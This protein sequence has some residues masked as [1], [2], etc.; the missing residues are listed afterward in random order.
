MSSL[1]DVGS[2]LIELSAVK[3]VL[4]EEKKKLVGY[5]VD[6]WHVWSAS[7]HH[8]IHGVYLDNRSRW[9]IENR[10]VATQGFQIP[11]S[12][13]TSW[14]PNSGYS[15]ECVNISFIIDAITA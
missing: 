2:F 10:V 1:R 4:E 5:G 12:A 14:L 3:R 15:S 6:Q 7:I 8:P 9:Q 11:Y 13:D